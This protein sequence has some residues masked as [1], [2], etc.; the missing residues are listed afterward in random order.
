[1]ISFG[2]D[3]GRI[4][5]ASASPRR[6]ALL[7]AACFAVEVRPSSV[8]ETWPGGSV[9]TGA[10]ALARRKLA[11]LGDDQSL[12]LA[13]DTVVLVGERRLGKPVDDREAMAML[14]EL[15]GRRHQ[16]V[17]GFCLARGSETRERSVT[18]EVWF[19]PLSELEIER[20]VASGEPF[21]K[22]GAYAIQGGA[23]A[24]VDRVIGSYTNVVG[25]PLAEVIESV[26][27][28]S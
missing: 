14:A 3:R 27:A 10:I 4:L 24:F 28:L 20:Y 8:E 11:A 5:L 17:T 2:M 18:T 23:G 26:E 7:E 9:E 22:A 15:A 16:V 12:R 21:D 19:R 6:R 1:M 13:A 25:L